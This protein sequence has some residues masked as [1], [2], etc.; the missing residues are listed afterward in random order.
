MLIF[1]L[2]VVEMFIIAYWTKTVVESR[3]Y[4]SGLITVVNILIWYYVLRIFV[5]NIDNWYLVVLYALGCAVGTMLSSLVS[6][7]EKARKKRKAKK[8]TVKV[9]KI[10]LVTE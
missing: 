7:K 1:I 8:P 4:M 6:N 3:I 10:S 2:G 5:D 9:R